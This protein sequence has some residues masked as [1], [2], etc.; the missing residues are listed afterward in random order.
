MTCFNGNLQRHP[1]FSVQAV[2]TVGAG[3]AFCGALAVALA[4]RQDAAD[5]LTQAIRFASAAGALAVTRNGAI[6]SLPTRQEVEA[7]L[8]AH[9]PVTPNGLPASLRTPPGRAGG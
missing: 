1:A 5:D 4:E 7:L 9:R 3:D 6:P 2:D 8:R